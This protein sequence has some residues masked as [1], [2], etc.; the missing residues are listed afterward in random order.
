MARILFAIVVQR[1]IAMTINAFDVMKRVQ[2]K[3][4]K[5]INNANCM[6]KVTYVRSQSEQERWRKK[7]AVKKTMRGQIN[8]GEA[9]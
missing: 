1:K 4:F 3:R 9:K 8:W 7:Q 6:V 5:P 2:G